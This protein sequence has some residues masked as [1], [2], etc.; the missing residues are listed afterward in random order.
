MISPMSLR[1]PKTAEGFD[2]GAGQAPCRFW[3]VMMTGHSCYPP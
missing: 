3:G 1:G 2:R